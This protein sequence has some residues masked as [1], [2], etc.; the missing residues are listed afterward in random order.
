VAGRFFNFDSQRG[1]RYIP[2]ERRPEEG[3]AH[4]IR[5]VLTGITLDNLI[6]RTKSQLFLTPVSRVCHEVLGS[7]RGLT[8]WKTHVYQNHFFSSLAAE[9]ASLSQICMIVSNRRSRL[10]G[11]ERCKEVRLNTWL[12]GVV[13]A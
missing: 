1:H 6:Q 5:K 8:S 12:D 4:Q 7:V 11:K 2:A 3:F 13:L 10:S 9:V